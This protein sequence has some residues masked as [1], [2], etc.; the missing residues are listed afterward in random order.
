MIIRGPTREISCE[1]CH[2]ILNISE[3]AWNIVFQKLD[4]F[5]INFNQS[6]KS[7]YKLPSGNNILN[8]K[9][10]STLPT[11]S[12]CHTQLDL[13][14]SNS[15][16][17][18]LRCPDCGDSTKLIEAPSWLEESELKKIIETKTEWYV[19]FQGVPRWLK[20][21]QEKEAL[22]QKKYEFEKKQRLHDKEVQKLTTRINEIDK[23]SISK[24]SAGYFASIM[25]GIFVIGF[26][27][28]FIPPLSKLVGQSICDGE[29][30][31]KTF[32][33]GK[34]KTSIKFYCKK[35]TA[36]ESID[37][38]MALFGPGAGI[39]FFCSLWT[40]YIPFNRFKKRKEIKLLKEQLDD[41]IA[42]GPPT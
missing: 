24:Y 34:G 13:K 30:Q 28:L 11:C 8:I 36:I 25:M 16:S 3:E 23:F 5:V 22:K 37:G 4:Q 31:R 35:G 10:K 38:Q 20:Q 41:L 9:M 33:T 40:L 42:K 17:E 32:K 21:K 7:S 14:G 26:P 27:I 6:E 18:E 39:L 2:E 12:K 15:F 19:R 29:Y 1:E